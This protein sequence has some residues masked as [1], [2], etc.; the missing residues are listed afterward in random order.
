MNRP[1]KITL[2][3][4]GILTVGGV[5]WYFV[6][7]NK[8]GGG[9]GAGNGSGNDEKKQRFLDVQKNLGVATTASV[10][11]VNFNSGV[12]QADFYDNGRFVISKKG[13]QGYTKKGSYYNGG[14][15]LVIDDGATIEGESVWTNLQKTI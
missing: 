1:L 14:K 6:S 13:T 3:S 4:L 10:F 11:S 5:I 15:K 12:N 7:R 2:I 8:G 9:G